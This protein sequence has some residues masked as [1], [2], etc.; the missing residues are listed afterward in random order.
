MNRC[1]TFSRLEHREIYIDYSHSENYNR[2]RQ[3]KRISLTMCLYNNTYILINVLYTHVFTVNPLH[4][5]ALCLSIVLYKPEKRRE[6]KRKKKEKKKHT[7][8]LHVFSLP[9]C[10]VSP[11]CT[12]LS[13]AYLRPTIIKFFNSTIIYYYL[14]CY[15]KQAYVLYA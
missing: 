4:N 6:K 10:V 15:I 8:T 9:L 1:W 13:R 12:R 7:Y 5:A 3:M 2:V 14:V 11:F